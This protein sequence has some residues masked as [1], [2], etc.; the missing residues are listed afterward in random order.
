MC[1]GRSTITFPS[2]SRY[3]HTKAATAYPAQ[4]LKW[5]WPLKVME[6]WMNWRWNSYNPAF[7][8]PWL[9]SAL[10]RESHKLQAVR[11]A[12]IGGT[13]YGGLPGVIPGLWSL[14]FSYLSA[15]LSSS[16]LCRLFLLHF[17]LSAALSVTGKCLI[18][19]NRSPFYPFRRE[20]IH[21]HYYKNLLIFKRASK[22][23]EGSKCCN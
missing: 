19:K 4:Q 14:I 16:I 21:L 23:Q 1:Q 2:E 13:E 8:I 12:T 17:H 5:E 6:E 15:A 18:S 22:I 9:N 11:E 7:P 20:P 10:S 3:S